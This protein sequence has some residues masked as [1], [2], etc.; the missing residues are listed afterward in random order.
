MVERDIAF[1]PVFVDLKGNF[2]EWSVYKKAEYCTDY[3][4][5]VRADNKT[6]LKEFKYNEGNYS[7]SFE[8][9]IVDKE[10]H[11]KT[12]T[13]DCPFSI[14]ELHNWNNGEI[15]T[16]AEHYKEGEKTY[17]CLGCGAIKTEAIAKTTNHTF[18]HSPKAEDYDIVQPA[19]NGQRGIRRLKCTAGDGY[20]EEQE[21]IA[22]ELPNTSGK[23]QHFLLKRTSPYS[24]NSGLNLARI[25]EHYISDNAY[26]YAVKRDAS[27]T[28]FALLWVDKGENSPVYV[29]SG[30]FNS[31]GTWFVP[32]SR[33]GSSESQNY[34]ILCYVNNRQE[35]MDL[36]EKHWSRIYV[37]DGGS[38]L[39]NFYYFNSAGGYNYYAELINKGAQP[40]KQYDDT[41]L[42]GWDKPL[43]V[44]D[45]KN[46]SYTETLYV[47][48]YN[49]CVRYASSGEGSVQISYEAVDEFPFSAPDRE[50]ITHYS[51]YVSG[52]RYDGVYYDGTYFGMTYIGENDEYCKLT[53]NNP[54]ED[55]L[56]SHWEKY[57]P[58]TKE[59]SYF[60]D[61]DFAPTIN[62][63][64]TLRA[65]YKDKLVH[66]K[67]EG[68][69]FEIDKGWYKWTNNKY[70][71]VDVKYNTII[72]VMADDKLTPDGKEVDHIE[73]ANGNRIT[74]NRIFITS[75]MEYRV[76]YVNKT[77]YVD[78]RAENGIVKKDGEVF[79]GERLEVGKE[80]TF[81]TE[82]SNIEQY[83]NF[84]GWCKIT[85]G[86]NKIYT[87]VSKDLTYKMTVA[88]DYN[89][90]N[91]I[92][93]WSNQTALPEYK[94]NYHNVEIINGLARRHGVAVSN[95][96]VSDD[97]SLK[98]I[99]D[100]SREM[101]KWV[102]TD[103]D[104]DNTPIE[105]Q[106]Y[107][108]NGNY[109]YIS[110]ENEYNEDEKGGKGKDPAS[111][112]SPENI[113]I[114]GY[115]KKY[116]VHTC[117]T[118]GGCTQDSSNT[119]CDYRKCTCDPSDKN[120]V[121]GE[122]NN[123]KVNLVIDNNGV[124]ASVFV[125]DMANTDNENKYLLNVN[126]ALN[127]WEIK[128]L[129]DITLIDAENKPYDLADGEKANVTIDVGV[130]NAQNLNNGTMF[131][132]HV[133]ENGVDVYGNG[134]M[135]MSVDEENGTVT[136]TADEF[137]PFGL[138]SMPSVTI[139][140][141]ANGGSGEMA[142]QTV[143]KGENFNLPNNSFTAPDG[144]K[145]KGWALSLTGE[146]LTNTSIAITDDTTLYAIW[147][148]A[149]VSK[150][151]TGDNVNKTGLQGGAIAGIV[152]GVLLLVALIGFIVYWFGAKKLTLSDL[153]NAVKKP[154][155][156]K[157]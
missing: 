15:T 120:T 23:V 66:V 148:N 95:L 62:D 115:F 99:R 119:S 29:R 93:V 128:E 154:F 72:K 92:A 46:G 113:R 27:P 12:C 1:Y 4:I 36:I 83:N 157:K 74:E 55:E 2:G 136:I 58:Y 42:E 85:Y 156:K 114:T 121:K 56:F 127:S 59:W 32:D 151:N 60:S 102:L 143:K 81:T 145:F 11:V 88:D 37:Y 40:I 31:E 22:A 124:M 94:V 140:F 135:A 90:N 122:Q 144:K 133:T 64:T 130:N 106:N 54:R 71:D 75:D 146:I 65:V 86:Y 149:S 16:E 87:L 47:D 118:C 111:T 49:V 5:Y 51:Y 34:G 69:Y 129:Y 78:V 73:D 89:S 155:N 103:V 8:Y 50:K 91:I 38:S 109:F 35:F 3:S 10:Y 108:E 70:N 28:G 153:G 142:S 21:Y 20:G 14:K 100:G 7:H 139:S 33:Y 48:D 82:S 25:E 116:C 117:S 132:A 107:N 79:S 13:N 26:Y 101:S 39:S 112:A 147:E 68:G 17:T 134:Y 77:V 53:H 141:D 137:S 125:V 41:T 44:F 105:T 6:G 104:G 123:G 76:V 52:G 80:Y 61:A 131:I 57:D 67:V 24:A 63:V 96:R 19:K 138:V 110:G 30:K 43:K 97:S 126:Q 9:T 150:G 152:I 18:P 98:V 84:L 45:F